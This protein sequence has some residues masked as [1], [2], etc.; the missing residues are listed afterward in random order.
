MR[1]PILDLSGS[2]QGKGE[3]F[4]KHIN[5]YVKYTKFLDYLLREFSAPWR[6]LVLCKPTALLA[7]YM[8]RQN[9]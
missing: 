4:S 7:W 6:M 2:E 8:Q 9:I 5:E 1:K 3:G